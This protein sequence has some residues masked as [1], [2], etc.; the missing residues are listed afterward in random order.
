VS[1]DIPAVPR[2]PIAED[3]ASLLARADEDASVA[4]QIERLAA[5]R[6]LRAAAML[7]RAATALRERAHTWRAIARSYEQA[8]E[9]GAE[10][11]AAIVED[12]E[13]AQL[14]FDRLLRREL[15][16]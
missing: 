6:P 13:R 15:A 10:A 7:R 11:R 4:G 1:G 5:G 16:R 2:P 9:L 12:E 3:V 14:A 8:A